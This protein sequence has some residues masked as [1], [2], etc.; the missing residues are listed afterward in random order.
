MNGLMCAFCR[1]PNVQAKLNSNLY[2]LRFILL[3]SNI[4][5]ELL[6]LDIIIR[7]WLPEI[8]YFFREENLNY[9]YDL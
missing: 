5:I 7:N 2:S 9:I 8:S 4:E 6:K 3:H 1:M